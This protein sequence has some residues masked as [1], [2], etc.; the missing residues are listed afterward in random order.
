MSKNEIEFLKEIVVVVV[1]NYLHSSSEVDE[2]SHM[3]NYDS[4]FHCYKTFDSFENI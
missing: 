4:S 1:D 3:K 2:V